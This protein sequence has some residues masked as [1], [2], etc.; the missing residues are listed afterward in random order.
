MITIPSAI[1]EIL[2]P[3]LAVQPDRLALIAPDRSL[4]YAELDAAADRAA[5]ALLA[6]GVSSGDRVAVSLPN[7]TRIV[8][9]FHAA[10]RLGAV[11]VGVNQALAAPERHTITSHSQARVFIGGVTGEAPA[12]TRVAS[13]AEWSALVAAADPVAEHTPVDPHA[14]AGIAYTSGTTGRQKGVVHSQHNLLVPGAM[15]IATRGWSHTM[16]KADCLPMTILNMQVLSTLTTCQA[17]ATAIISEVRDA[18]RIV[19]W[20]AEHR[21]Q[22]WNGV[23]PMLYDM[24]HDPSIAPDALRFL[25]E[26]WSGGDNL[27]EDIRAAFT[28]KFGKPILGTYGL[29]EAPTIV[30]IDPP[31]G[32]HLPNESG[33]VLPHLRIVIEPT[34]VDDNDVGELCVAAAT[35]GPYAG[36]YTPMLGY[37]DDPEETTATLRDGLLHTGDIGRVTEAGRISVRDRRKLVIVRGGANIY[38]AEVEGV[39]RSFPGVRG[40]AVTPVADERLG[41]RVGAVVEVDGDAVNVEALTQHCAAALARY[42][43]PERWHL[44]TMPLPR[45]AMGKIDRSSLGRLLTL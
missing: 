10:M 40:V 42:K 33:A 39:I 21:A 13:E 3:V 26:L 6:L 17:G 8:A 32:G 15:L 18:R 36:L 31:S 29:T 2:R 41:A 7:D 20:L 34:D 12:Q 23:P 22:V 38:P 37:L 45:N 24:A 43:V 4:T 19:A 25:D 1:G 44:T 9:L 5:G 16:R 27:S 30:A 28:A 14:P 35:D 11:W